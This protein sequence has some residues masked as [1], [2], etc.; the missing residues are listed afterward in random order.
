MAEKAEKEDTTIRLITGVTVVVV[1][2]ALLLT[3]EIEGGQVLIVNRDRVSLYAD[4]GKAA[5]GTPIGRIE[6]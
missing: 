2:D 6:R 4:L 3:I 1:N 5:E